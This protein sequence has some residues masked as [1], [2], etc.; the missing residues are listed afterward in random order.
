MVESKNTPQL[1]KLQGSWIIPCCVQEVQKEDD[2]GSLETFYQYREVRS[3]AK[4]P[5]L[6]EAQQVVWRY[7]QE[8]L[9]EHIY[10]EYDQGSQSSIQGMGQDA[11]V[12][13]REVRDDQKLESPQ[14]TEQEAAAIETQMKEIIT[15]CRAV[16]NW[17]NDC[18]G[19]YYGKKADIFAASSIDDLMLV[20]WDFA[21]NVT[22]P[23]S[24][25]T[26]SEIRE[27]FS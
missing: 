22:K 23:E 15:E 12:T 2:E 5:S 24:L 18:L 19:Y 25:K 10:P 16:K 1:Q 17:I 4:K 7:L 3:G 6:T 13:I 20:T 21:Q 11:E 27:M 9:H 8:C 26:L 14:Y